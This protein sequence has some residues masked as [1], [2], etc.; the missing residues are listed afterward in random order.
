[1]P[2]IPVRDAKTYW[3]LSLQSCD[4]GLCGVRILLIEVG[5]SDA[6]S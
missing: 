6:R 5:R 1:M 2:F 4:F 3:K